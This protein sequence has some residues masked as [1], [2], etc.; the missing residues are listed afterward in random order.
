VL[1][2]SDEATI[3]RLETLAKKA[4]FAVAKTTIEL[5]GRCAACAAAA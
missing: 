2:L 1:E 3:H 5:R 4:D